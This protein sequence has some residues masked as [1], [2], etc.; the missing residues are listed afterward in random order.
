MIRKNYNEEKIQKVTIRYNKE[1][2]RMLKQEKNRKVNTIVDTK[3]LSLTLHLNPSLVNDINHN[4]G[5]LASLAT[6]NL[7]V[8]CT[9]CNYG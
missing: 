2:Y 5:K 6:G 3:Q 9:K 8:H 1:N 4:K 7:Q